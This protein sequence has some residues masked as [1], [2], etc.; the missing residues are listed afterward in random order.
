MSASRRLASVGM[1]AL[2]VATACVGANTDVRFV[3]WDKA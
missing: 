2:L 3:E 1:L